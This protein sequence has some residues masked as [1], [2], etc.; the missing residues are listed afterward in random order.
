MN[1]G[2]KIANAAGQLRGFEPYPYYKNS[3]VEWLG[4]IPAHWDLK[5]IKF[6]AELN[7]LGSEARGL[8]AHTEVSFVPMEAVGELGGLDLSRRKFLGDVG[9]GYTYFRDGDI[10]VAKITPCF[11]NGK[12]ALAE[13]L[14]NG[15]AFG[16]TEL[17]VFRANSLLNT[18]FLFYMTLGDAL[19]RLGEADMYGA[20]GQKRVS[21][22]FFRN[23][24]HPLPPE[25]EQRAIADFL[26]RETARIDDLIARKKR[27][28]ALLKEQR[29]SLITRAVTKG[30]DP[31]APM[32]ESGVEWL[33]EIPEHWDSVRMWRISQAMSGATPA[34]DEQAYWNGGIPWVSPKDM[35]RRV[36]DASK[37]RVTERAIEETGIRLI[38]PPVVLIVVRGMI[39]A[40]SFPV[41]LATVPLTINQ[42]M[43][44][45]ILRSDISPDFTVWLFEGIGKSLLP[46]I[47][48]D[49]AH[50]TKAIRMDQW[51]C[52]TLPLPDE[53][54]QRSIVAFLDR[55][56][57]RIDTLVAKVRD[58]IDRLKELRTALIS[59][60]VTG[61]IDVRGESA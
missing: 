41:A 46:A 34:R 2:R 44:A 5:R 58:A 32:K 60:A 52:V 36:I 25:P 20:G 56:T 16:T 27:L 15:L 47:V 37:E 33:G 50:G 22:S 17:H 53:L 42:D 24:K 9:A 45:L 19:R 54:E 11:E 28:I 12:G 14:A 21:E 31:N 38:T 8:S 29:T 26:D 43:K 3:G 48:E 6:A 40:H 59:A 51:R 39:L 4:Q 30:L 49:A 18:R 23:L 1:S 35:K 7:P 10:V 55:E 13:G 61:K 57:T